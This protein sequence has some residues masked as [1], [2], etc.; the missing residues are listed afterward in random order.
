MNALPSDLREPRTGRSGNPILREDA[1]ASGPPLRRFGV[2]DSASDFGEGEAVVVRFVAIGGT[3]PAMTAGR[4]ACFARPAAQGRTGKKKP[5]PA[6]PHLDFH[7]LPLVPTLSTSSVDRSRHASPARVERRLGG[8]RR[9]V[10]SRLPA[11]TLATSSISVGARG[12][13]LVPSA[14]R[15]R[16]VVARGRTRGKGVLAA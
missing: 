8:T 16:A 11:R 7:P 2:A 13:K 9:H 10:S 5:R 6:A 3:R 15:L 14:D 1:D 4:G 12:A